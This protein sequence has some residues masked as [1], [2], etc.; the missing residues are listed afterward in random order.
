MIFETIEAEGLAHYS[1][2][3][4]DDSA[5]TCV[6]IDPRRDVDIYLDIARRTKVTISH[7]LETHIHA[8]FVSGSLELAAR[9]GATIGVGRAD[10]YGFEH[11]PLDDGD[12]IEVGQLTL[13]ALH[14][15]GHTPEH[16]SYL[17]G[18]GVGAGEPWGLFSGD[19]IFAGEI[20][21]PDLLGEG[22]EQKLARQLYH[23]LHEKLL[24]LGDEIIV[25][26][27]HGEGSPCGASIGDRPTTTIGYERLHNP[28]LHI[29]SVEEFTE[30]LLASQTPAPSYY[31]RMKKVNAAGP[32]LLSSLP[33]LRSLEV[34]TFIEQI[35]RPNTVV[36]DARDFEAFGGA[37]IPGSLN[38]GLRE[39]FPVWAG[40]ILDETF[41]IWTGWML[42]PTHCL[43][44]ILPEEDK[45]DEV[46]RHLHRIGYENIG[47]Y[48]REGIRGWIKAGQEFERTPQMSVHELKQRIDAGDRLQIVDARTNSEWALGR[49]PT[50]IH[51]YV[52]FLE[53]NLDKLDPDKPVATYCG[54]G[55]RASIAASI[56][57]RHGFQQVYNIPGSM[58]AWQAA[59]YEVEKG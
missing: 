5:G 28:L 25:Y 6:V 50:A 19:T 9:T 27:A 7:V 43:L 10:E 58:T 40:R 37:H 49:I 38:I 21:R 44:L 59:G 11:T 8:D 47:G 45:V 22:T 17:V 57:K 36:V 26:P 30:R 46:V 31:P 29:D 24:K 51:S 34:D 41:P 32:T 35:E 56:L 39:P 14:T 55:Y 12:R 33:D 2:V 15:P 42:D 52:P 18:G 48:L 4:G 54:S 53:E 1:Y 13:T 3:I 20:G 23:T 16:I